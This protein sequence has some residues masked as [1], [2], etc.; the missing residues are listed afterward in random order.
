MDSVNVNLNSWYGKVLNIFLLGIKPKNTCSAFKLILVMAIA[1]PLQALTL[2]TAPIYL[3]AAYLRGTLTAVGPYIEKNID[4][5]WLYPIPNFLSPSMH[6]VL[7]LI[8]IA[9]AVT[10]FCILILAFISF[11]MWSVH[12]AQEKYPKV[13]A[14]IRSPSSPPGII[15]SSTKDFFDRVCRPIN[16][17]KD[18]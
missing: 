11:L 9:E 17:K 1:W 2:F 6:V 18:N 5:L 16:W 13:A 10:L 15:R 4:A 12:N 3:H 7:S 8:T 14:Y